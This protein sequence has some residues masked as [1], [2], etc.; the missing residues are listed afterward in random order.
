MKKV[1]VKLYATIDKLVKQ[2]TKIQ[3][4]MKQDLING[5]EKSFENYANIKV[6]ECT[7]KSWSKEVQ[8]ELDEY[9]KSKGYEKVETQYKRVD[10]DNVNEEV[11]NTI[12]EVVNM[13]DNSNNKLVTKVASK[14]AN[15]KR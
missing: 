11:N 8:Q 7:R 4:E 6:V 1:N 15:V 10:I 9:A 5:A 12:E 13:L 14:V 3:N 2:L